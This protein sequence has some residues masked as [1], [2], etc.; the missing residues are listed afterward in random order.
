MTWRCPFI[1]PPKPTW[2]STPASSRLSRRGLGKRRCRWFPRVS[3]DFI[4]LFTCLRHVVL[5]S[6]RSSYEA[7]HYAFAMFSNSI[8]RV[9]GC[10]F[11]DGTL[12]SSRSSPRASVSKREKRPATLNAAGESA[13]LAWSYRKLR[14]R[15]NRW[16]QRLGSGA[17]PFPPRAFRSSCGAISS[18]WAHSGASAPACSW[19]LP[20]PECRARVKRQLHL[21]LH[22][23][24][25]RED[26][27]SV[28]CHFWKIPWTPRSPFSVSFGAVSVGLPRGLRLGQKKNLDLNSLYFLYNLG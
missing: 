7:L 1:M 12:T 21:P 26:P 8:P 19:A 4:C 2:A 9:H 22:P 17:R 5:C 6:P 25:P 18:P 28:S 20:S 3:T 10:H 16:W 15:L 11:R 23:R 27:E 14:P 13:G 24:L